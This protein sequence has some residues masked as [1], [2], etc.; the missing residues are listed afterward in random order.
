[1]RHTDNR[2]LTADPSRSREVPRIDLTR[3]PVLR[4]LC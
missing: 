4:R 1:M 2:P 3:R